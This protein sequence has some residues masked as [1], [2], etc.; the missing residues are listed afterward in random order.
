VLARTGLLIAGLALATASPSR[1]APA[2]RAESLDANLVL[3]EVRLDGQVLSDAVTAYQIGSDVFLPLGEMARLLTLAIRVDAPAGRANGY[4]LHEDR[5]FNLDVPGRTVHTGA[6][7]DAPAALDPAQVRVLADDI[8]VASRQLARWLPVDVDADMGSLALA[9]RPR[10]P[11]PLQGRLA[12]R[13]RGGMLGIGNYVDPGYPHLATPYRAISVPFI[14]QT[15]SI[16]TGRTGG[17]RHTDTAYTGY[18]T[19]DLAGMEAALYVSRN[20]RGPSSGMRLTL[21]RNDPDGALLGPLHAR[22]FA[23]GSIAVPGTDNLSA[24]SATGNGIALGNRPLDRPTSFD[25][26]SLQGILAPG[27]DVELYYNEALVGFQ[28]SRPDGKYVFDDLALAFGPNEFRLVFHGPLGQS[29]VE[30][31]S[32]L[33]E[34]SAVPRG[35][36]YYDLAMQRDGLHRERAL[37]Q[38]EWGAGEHVN[39]LGGWQ[40]VPVADGAHDYARLGLR[41]YWSALIVT[42]DVIRADDGGRLAQLGLKT[43]VGNIALSATRA[44]LDGFTSELFPNRADLV[45]VRDTL[46][47]E[48]TILPGG[49]GVVIP[50]AFDVRRELLA[51][52]VQDIDVQGRVSVYRDGAA[53]SNALRWQSLDGRRTAGGLL[54]ASRRVAGIGLT[55]QLEYQLKPRGRLGSAALLADRT[56]ADGYQL[57]LGLARAF[58]QREMRISAALNKSLGTYGLGVNVFH[59]SRHAYG[60]GVQ[61]FLALGREPRTARLLAEA[62]PMAGMGSASVRVFLDRNGNGVADA[63]DE[64]VRNAGFLINGANYLVRTDAAGLAYL[65]R[66]PAH[67]HTDIGLASDTLE[68]PQWQPRTKGVRIVPRPG[69]VSEIDFAVSTTGEIDGT[70]YLRT[71]AVRRP[72]GELQ[73]ELVDASGKVVAA[74]ATASDGYYVMTG[75]FPGKYLLRVAPAQLAHLHLQGPA[76]QPVAIG[77]EGTVIDGRDIEVTAAVQ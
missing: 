40:R 36:V 6:P 69:A 63:G 38:V 1:A 49:G 54:Q 39:V 22:T 55:G 29:R 56:L 67:Q 17:P 59:T 77:L 3:L 15:L 28:Q 12:R 11:L 10:E 62:Q 66:L 68:D 43:R 13:E 61:F 44:R 60:A 52:G 72:V 27:W 24:T 35:T 16:D 2:A 30:R 76:P 34:Q 9:V 19:A 20:R 74:G 26:T 5:V 75:I 4:I 50:L 21:G 47:A 57:N 51:S 32:F 42:A 37:A 25:R 33:L 65:P 48:G 7:G 18:L 31:R 46:R 70:A 14:D 41:G 58:D 73:L 64:P 23:V 53:L 45:R 71:T 8:Y